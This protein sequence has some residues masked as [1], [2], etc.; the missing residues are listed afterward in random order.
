MPNC[1][2]VALDML[3]I[4]KTV[5]VDASEM[6]LTEFSEFLDEANGRD[7]V[8]TMHSWN[9]IDRFFWSSTHVGS[10]KTNER[11]FNGMIK[12]AK[13]KGYSF[14]SLVDYDF[15]IE[16][17]NNDIKYNA[18][19]TYLKKIRSL[20]LNFW[21]FQNMAKISK[22]YLVIYSIFYCFLFLLLGQLIIS[23]LV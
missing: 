4:K 5:G 23:M 10:N 9:F 12:L 14:A 17:S 1:F 3:G 2:F 20:F 18:C 22:K 19:G 21:R 15:K 11:L 6:S 8:L 13:E 16:G 7:F